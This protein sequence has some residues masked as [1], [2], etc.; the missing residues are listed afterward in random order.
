MMQGRLTPPRGRGIQFFP[1]DNWAAEFHL[2]QSL[3]LSEIEWIFDLTDYQPNPLWTSAGRQE[4]KALIAKTGVKVNFIC[5]DYFVKQPLTQASPAVQEKNATVLK[6]LL[7]AAREIGARGLEIPCLDNSSIKSKTEEAELIQILKPS[8]EQARSHNLVL[9]LEM[10]YP[11]AKLCRLLAQL[12]EANFG[13]TYDSGNSSGLGY[14]CAEELKS[15]GQAV[16]NVHIKDRLLGNGTKPLGTGSADFEKLFVGL[17]AKN[18]AGHYILQA[19]RG[20]D[21]QEVA[22]IKSQLDFVTNYLNKYQL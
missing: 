21:G 5:V 17:K 16:F 15:Y 18:Y 1:A 9:S 2:G 6:E 13:I 11:P 8:L 3:G 19:A 20:A 12:P 14:D 10:D 4:I 22:T 7:S